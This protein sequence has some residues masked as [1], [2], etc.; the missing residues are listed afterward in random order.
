MSRSVMTVI[1]KMTPALKRPEVDIPAIEMQL[2]GSWI[3]LTGNEL[4]FFYHQGH[5]VLF[6]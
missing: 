1:R 2:C 4:F 5:Y 6:F 3:A